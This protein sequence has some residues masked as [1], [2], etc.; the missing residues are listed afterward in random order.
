MTESAA[1]AHRP[2]PV[3]ESG[4][5]ELIRKED[6]WA[7]WIG[8]GLIGVAFGLFSNGGS[9]KWLAVAPQKWSHLDDALTQLRQNAARYGVL[10]LF[11]STALGGGAAALGIPLARFLRAFVPLYVVTALIY[12]VGLWDQSAHYNLEPPLVALALGLLVSNTVGVPEWL[13]PALRVEFYIKTGIVLLG[14]SLPLTQASSRSSPSGSSISA[15]CSSGL[16][17]AWQ[18]RS[19]PAAPCAA[20]RARLQSAAPSVQGSRMCRSRFR[21]SS[22]MRS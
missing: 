14:A 13:S 20:Y 22:S 7:V 3:R 8:L 11:W 16:T 6:W 17:G 2:V 4:W 21:W 12:F 15:R 19:V 9:L 18:R 1:V 5:L 10:L